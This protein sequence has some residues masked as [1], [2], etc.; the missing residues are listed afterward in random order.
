MDNSIYR[1][2]TKPEREV[3]GYLKEVGLRWEFERQ[4]VSSMK[5]DSNSVDTDNAAL[6]RNE[7][8]ERHPSKLADIHHP[9]RQIL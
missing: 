2:M 6:H 7:Y 5:T 1:R 3:A 9:R 8:T 4:S